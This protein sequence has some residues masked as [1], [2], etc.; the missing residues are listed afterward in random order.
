MHRTDHTQSVRQRA[1]PLLLRIGTHFG[2]RYTARRW[3]DS[4]AAVRLGIGAQVLMQE[5]PRHDFPESSTSGC[6]ADD[7][8]STGRVQAA[9]GRKMMQNNERR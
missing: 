9:R 1:V 5:M 4:S 2:V 3:Q 7:Y 8:A 6:P